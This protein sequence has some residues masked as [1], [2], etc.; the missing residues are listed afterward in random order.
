MWQL[1]FNKRIASGTL[2][3]IV[4]SEGVSIDKWSRTIGFRRAAVKDVENG[5]FLDEDMQILN[6]YCDG[7]NAF[8][9]SNPVLAPEFSLLGIKPTAWEP[10][11]IIA[12]GKI[13]AWGLSL[14]GGLEAMRYAIMANK[15]ISVDRINT[16]FPAYP[17]NDPSAPTVLTK[18]D[19]NINT[20]MEEDIA[21]ENKFTND[22]AAYYP[23]A[24]DIP[25]HTLASVGASMGAFI[26]QYMHLTKTLQASNNWVVSGKFTKDKNAILCDDPHLELTAPSIWMLM[27][28]K[29]NNGINA[30]GAVFPGMP[31]VIIGKNEHIAWGVTNAG[32]DVQD[33]FVMQDAGD[34]KYHHK[35]KTLSY[36]VVKEVIKVKGAANIDL[37][38]QLT[39]YGPIINDVMGLEGAKEKLALWWVAIQPGDTTASSFSRIFRASDWTSFV[40]ALKPYVVPAQNF[41]FADKDARIGYYMP[42]KV[43]IRREGHSGRFPVIGDGTYDFMD[44]PDGF[45]PF[46]QLPHVFEPKSGF[47]ISANNRIVPP[48]YPYSIS[49]DFENKYRAW[50]IHE[51]ITERVSTADIDVSF[52][53]QLM[54]DAYSKLF[55]EYK[56]AL[57]RTEGI[58]KPSMAS[59]LKMLL[60]WNGVQGENIQQPTVFEQWFA[61]LTKLTEPE[62]GFAIP[63]RHSDFLKQAILHEDPSCMKYHNMS[64][65]A[66]VSHALEQAIM[67]LQTEYGNNI[68]LWGTEIHESLMPHAILDNTL[69]GCLA[70]KSVFNI[71]GTFT[72]NVA[73]TIHPSLQVVEGVSYRQIVTMGP[74]QENREMDQFIIPLGQSGN[75]LSKHYANW[76]FMWRDGQFLPMDMKNYNK[77]ASLTLA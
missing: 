62:I 23:S 22:S 21:L 73:S 52:M 57:Q 15:R 31:G 58:V 49:Q 16:L 40:E 4:G 64:C 28:I 7:I 60:E 26:D 51:K 56:F 50:R 32:A 33:L 67:H 53:K 42:G 9:K 29:S 66:F 37:D 65:T 6:A 41:I 30:M 2:S 46:E 10:A 45:I 48:G 47:I 5:A 20:T 14:N 70:S 27:H 74:F 24:A 72:V 71:G 63:P 11:D 76:M 18:E 69:L 44:E 59:W 43:P 39:K 1:E 3:E 35:G 8:Y 68:P 55:E 17:I 36:E 75:W 54:M 25:T 12:W 13:V 61:E 34:G 77:A 38:V 19:L